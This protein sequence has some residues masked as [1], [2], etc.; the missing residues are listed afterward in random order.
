MQPDFD[1]PTGHHPG[2][3]ALECYSLGI[4]SE[5]ETGPIEEHLLICTDC[6]Q[7]L[8][9]TDEYTR[10]VRTAAAKLRSESQRSRW[11]F[12]AKLAQPLGNRTPAW[13]LALAL[14]A[15]PAVWL[16]VS[17]VSST[18]PVAVLLQ[19]AR[20]PAETTAHAPRGKT[21]TLEMEAAQLPGL[22]LYAV[23]IVDASGSQVWEG[24]GTVRDGLIVTEPVRSLE[25]GRYWVR[26]YEP[27]SPRELL[28]EFGLEVH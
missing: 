1:E 11:G 15:L 8:R 13:G 16:A 14:L 12:L 28:R 7:R 23:E 24:S 19:S 20:G 2:E 10:A 26:L 18:P 17:R 25:P 6:Q 3:D 9:D 27:G 5:P 21:L 4:L 22:P